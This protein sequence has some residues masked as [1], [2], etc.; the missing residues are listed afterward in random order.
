VTIF[1]QFLQVHLSGI[2]IT[3]LLMAAFVRIARAVYYPGFGPGKYY[4]IIIVLIF[5]QI[6]GCPT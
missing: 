3:G 5:A 2:G 6:H 1:V 4:P